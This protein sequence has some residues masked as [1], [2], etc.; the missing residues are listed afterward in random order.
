M[1]SPP[2]KVALPPAQVTLPAASLPSILTMDGDKNGF[3]THLNMDYLNMD[4]D[5]SISMSFSPDGFSE[6]ENQDK[7]H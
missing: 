1:A 7:K 3:Y 5:D 4:E 2:A 6:E